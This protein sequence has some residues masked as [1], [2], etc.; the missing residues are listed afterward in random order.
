MGTV[1]I[2]YA[3]HWMNFLIDGKINLF[4]IYVFRAS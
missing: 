1:I 2:F 3:I 4:V